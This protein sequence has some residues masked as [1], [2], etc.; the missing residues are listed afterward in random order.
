MVS[1]EKSPPGRNTD[2]IVSFFELN[3]LKRSEFDCSEGRS[4]LNQDKILSLVWNNTSDLLAMRKRHCIEL[5]YRSNYVW[6][7]K[8]SI[9][10]RRK[11]DDG[12][13]ALDGIKFFTW[14]KQFAYK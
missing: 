1:L 10:S 11:G 12:K 13:G 8:S 2:A 14:D 7:C 9:F 3:G 4:T 6:M 5:W